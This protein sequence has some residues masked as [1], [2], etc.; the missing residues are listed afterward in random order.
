MA[1]PKAEIVLRGGRVFQGLAEGFVTAL[2]VWQ[3][4]VLATGS[5]ADMAPLI[6]PDTRVVEL[7]GRAVVPGFNDAH[8]H[9]LPLGMALTEIDLRGERVTT[10]DELL[11]R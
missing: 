8:Q 10:L 2:A 1:L 5:D 11:R 7:R 9:L 3:G 4:R 6:G